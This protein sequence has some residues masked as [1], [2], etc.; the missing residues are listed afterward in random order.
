[1]LDEQTG[2]PP[3]L[4]GPPFL[5]DQGG[6]ALPALDQTL[7]PGRHILSTEDIKRLALISEMTLFPRF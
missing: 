5:V 1:M 7:I 2:V 3:H 6:V 4:V